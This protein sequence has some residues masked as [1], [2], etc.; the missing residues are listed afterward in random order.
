MTGTRR[1]ARALGWAVGLWLAAHGALLVWGVVDP[2][3]SL[4]SDRTRSR[5]TSAQALLEAPGA[6]EAGELLVS[7]G[8]PGDYA[9]HA[10]VLGAADSLAVVQA[11]Q[12]LL[13]ALALAAVFGIV[14]DLGGARRTAWTAVAIYALIPIDFVVPH[15]LVSEAFFNP[16]LVFGTFALVRYGTRSAHARWLLAAGAAFGLAGVTRTEGLPWLLAMFALAVP[17]ARRRAPARALAHLALLA[18]L[19]FGPASLYLTLA[20]SEPVVLER[21][22]R[23]LGWELANRASRVSTAAGGDASDVAGEPLA[24]FLRTAAAHPLAFAREWALQAMKLLALPDNLDVARYLGAYEFTGRRSEWVHEL[25]VLGAVGRTFREM[26]GLASW[27]L[28]T[29][30]IWL[31]VLAL[32]L[33]G[34]WTA[35]RRS[36]GAERLLYL[37]LLALPIVWTALRVLAQ[38]ESRKRS[39]VDFALAIF[40]AIGA[41]RASAAWR[42]RGSAGRDAAGSDRMPPGA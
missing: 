16:L 37:I 35:L 33:G 26:P 40:A 17:L 27:L 3:A 32:A 18:A 31:G 39:P 25:G 11:V 13:A 24:A 23:S 42:G 15:Y 38:G 8:P 28:A 10:L 6:R 36:A 30:L 4:R 21:A 29:V 34:A 5:L 1:R 41:L 14:R 12:L 19:A 9:W 20:P 22:T 2:E 7:Q